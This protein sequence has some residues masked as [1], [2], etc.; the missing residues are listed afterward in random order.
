MCHEVVGLEVQITNLQKDKKIPEKPL[1][2]DF[3]K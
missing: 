3:D 2:L 1:H